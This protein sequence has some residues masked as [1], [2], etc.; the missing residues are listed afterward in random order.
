[1]LILGLK[2]AGNIVC[3]RRRPARRMVYA[4]FKAE[5][6]QELKYKICSINVVYPGIE[7]GKKS[8]L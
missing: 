4:A 7:A 1:M 6:M 2:Q 3:V 5:K 8:C